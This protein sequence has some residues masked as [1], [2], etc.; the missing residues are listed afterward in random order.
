MRIATSLFFGL[1]AIAL[2]AEPARPQSTDD[3]LSLYAVHINRTPKQSWTGQGVYL[4][5]GIII[6]AAHVVGFAFW[7]W[8]RVE[9]AGKDLPATVIKEGSVQDVDLTLL[10]VDES[11]LPISLRLRRMPLCKDT[12]WVGEPVIVATPEGVA[13]SNVMSPQ[14]LPTDIPVK[15]RTVIRYVE[16]TGNSGSGVFDANKKC[17]LGIISRQIS[18]DH[19]KQENGYR[20]KMTQAIAKYFVPASTIADFIPPEVRF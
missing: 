19:V 12:L 8:P 17:L 7:T 9:I 1:L 4:G 13:R 3:S 20:T 11:E 16:E 6:T 18:R 5:R 14:L 2:S 10:S 15:L